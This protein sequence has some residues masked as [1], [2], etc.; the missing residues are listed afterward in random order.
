M[1]SL[2]TFTLNE[3]STQGTLST[4][5]LTNRNISTEHECSICFESLSKSNTIS[6]C[7]NFHQFCSSCVKQY[8]ENLINQ[9]KVLKIPCLQD[10][11]GE[12]IHESLVK[13]VL[14]EETFEK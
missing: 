3:L 6:I 5:N 10:G 4:T 7:S 8:L 9:S 11:C 1:N 12:I 14:D 13:S 2:Q